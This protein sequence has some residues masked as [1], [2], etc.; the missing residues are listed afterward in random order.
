MAK[1]RKQKEE[2]SKDLEKKIKGA[3]GV[4]FSNFMGLKVK[5]FEEVRRELAKEEGEIVVTKK[6]LLKRILNGLG[7]KEA[8]PEA[9]EGGVAV[10]ISQKDEVMPAKVLAKYSKSFPVIKFYGG[11]LENKFIDAA[12]VKELSMLPSKT[13]LL[14]RVVGSINA[15]VSGFVNVLA[16]NLRGLINIFNQI[17]ERR[18]ETN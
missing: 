8:D 13:E 15:P 10:A 9:F 6:T 3:K 5:E 16:G 1:T 12:K 7:Y 4:V 14:S 2:I 18:K 17:Y 11:I